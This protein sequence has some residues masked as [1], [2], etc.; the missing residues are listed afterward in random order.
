MQ[1]LDLH[2]EI[3]QMRDDSL[4]LT[5]TGVAEIMPVGLNSHAFLS[6]EVAP[7]LF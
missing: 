3:K 1:R 5:Q 6:R 2:L 4:A 7:K